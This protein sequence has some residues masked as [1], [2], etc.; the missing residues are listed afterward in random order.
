MPIA[1]AGTQA[2][3]SSSFSLCPAAAGN[4]KVEL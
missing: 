1:D 3:Q 4:L 2:V